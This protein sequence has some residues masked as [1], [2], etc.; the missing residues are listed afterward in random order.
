VIKSEKREDVNSDNNICKTALFSHL[1]IVADKF[2]QQRAGKRR[3]EGIRR[4]RK[5]GG[6]KGK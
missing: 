4:G 6:Y 3:E 2:P 1:M 5:E